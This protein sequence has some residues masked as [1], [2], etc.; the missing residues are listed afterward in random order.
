[1]GLPRRVTITEVVL[2]DG[3]QDEPAM[4]A[5]A[6]KLALLEGLVTAGLRSIEI[7]AFV[8]P[9]RVPQMA[10]TDAL[11]ASLAAESPKTGEDAPVYSAL[12]MNR[13]GAE[14]ALAAGADEVRLV[15]SAS[16]GHSR[17]NGGRP[18][19]EALD[20]LIEAAALLRQA[21]TPPILS[22]GIATAFVCPYDGLTPPDRLVEIA[23][24]LTASGVRSISLADTLGAATPL[25]VRAGVRAVQTAHPETHVGLHLHDTEG[26]A[27]ANVWEALNLGVDWFDTA[28]GG[29]GGCPFAPGAAGNLATEDLLGLLHKLGIDT[30]VD[31]ERLTAL[32]PSLAQLVDHPL[33][34]RRA[35]LATA[36]PAGAG[37]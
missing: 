2:R 12:V 33:D 24:R 10:D 14:R 22:A 1:M 31:L 3:L 29:I 21:R 26:M 19:A 11:F 27:L 4:V 7:G 36:A 32:T 15:V 20:E 18:V 28:L 13:R 37:S 34:S 9:D 6:E 5:T 30:G 8:L 25:Q 35:R 23:D 16:E 17:S